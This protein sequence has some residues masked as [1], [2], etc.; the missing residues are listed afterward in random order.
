M[1]SGQEPI[2]ETRRVHWVDGNRPPFI[3]NE[4]SRSQQRRLAAQR[5]ESVPEFGASRVASEPSYGND[6]PSQRACEPEPL[7][8]PEPEPLVSFLPPDPSVLTH[9]ELLERFNEL[10]LRVFN[11]ENALSQAVA[12][13]RQQ[14]GM[15]AGLRCACR[16][17]QQKDS[18]IAD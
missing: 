14:D 3:E 4:P 5:G 18:I 11:S 15:L 12:V 9:S 10:A 1:S 13:V 17:C 16:A 6:D 8:Q 7:P 2:R